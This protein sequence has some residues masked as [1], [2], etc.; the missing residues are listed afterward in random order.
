ML[1]KLLLRPV[2]LNFVLA[3]L[4]VSSMQ[5]DNA[6]RG[7]SLKVDGP[8]DLRLNPKSGKPV[9]EI[10]KI[11]SQN[12]LEEILFE[13]ADEPYSEVIAEAITLHIKKGNEISTTTQLKEVI[14][15]ALQFIHPN[16]RAEKVKKSCRLCFQALRIYV[17]DEFGVL[18]NFS[19]NFPTYYRPMH[20]WLFSHFIREKT[21]E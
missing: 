15:N 12:E 5:I 17:N 7:F 6:N 21:G 20:V 18:K 16:E 1:I 19:K 2:P 13:N 4:G 8:L 3:D 9:S 10:L 14:K 11:I